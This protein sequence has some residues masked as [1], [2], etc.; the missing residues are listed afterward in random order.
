MSSRPII[1]NDAQ[2]YIKNIARHGLHED[3]QWLMEIGRFPV[4]CNILDVGCG[5]G[6]LIGA[7]ASEKNFARSV[8]GIELSH[9]LAD[10]ALNSI[11]HTGGK[12]IQGNFLTWL[13][14]TGWQPDTLI[15]SFFLHHCDE[16]YSYLRR[17]SDLLP[18]GG[19]L[20]IIDRIAVDESTHNTFPK[21]WKEI[22][23]SEHEWHEE[24][25]RISTVNGL[26]SAAKK[27]GFDFVRRQINPHD[28][29][30]GAEGFPKTLMEFWRHQS[31]QT[32]P[33]AL[34][35][36]PAHRAIVG[37]II[38]QLAQAGLH[39]IRRY[40]I[41]YTDDLIR[42]LYWRCP[43]RE[44]LLRFVGEFCP[45]SNA[46]VLQ[47]AGDPTNPELLEKLTQF[48]K[49]HRHLWQIINGPTTA[50]GVKAII[51]PFH[52]A[53]PYESETLAFLVGLQS[54]VNI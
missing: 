1:D 34:I 24:M 26:I 10:F 47:I 16:I 49:T 23:Y 15:M 40:S 35:V 29:R 13:P 50:N 27:A 7:L 9:V 14:P 36:S 6:A 4:G 51:L 32:F 17:A 44:P 54:G 48:K 53:E 5:T 42:K 31:G 38:Q 45:E 43:W 41:P 39:V 19:R 3:I 21:F 28:K 30:V 33:A 8:I 2:N 22:Y 52:V 37:E 20:Y 46:T 11:D 18:H 25:P 12:V